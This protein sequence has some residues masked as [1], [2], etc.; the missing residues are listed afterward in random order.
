MPPPCYHDTTTILSDFFAQGASAIAA[1]AAAIAAWKSYSLARATEARARDAERVAL[2][3]ALL[4]SAHETVADA[5][6]AEA[7]CLERKV[8]LDSISAL[9]GNFGGS[10]HLERVAQIEERGNRAAEIR[11]LA[12]AFIESNHSAAK[13]LDAEDLADRMPQSIGRLVEVRGIIENTRFEYEQG[14]LTQ[15]GML[16]RRDRLA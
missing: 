11:R 2:I 9:S 4:E 7:L 5:K 14:T 10:A 1:I 13:G 16:A 12:E 15:T 3:R 8:Q 6:R